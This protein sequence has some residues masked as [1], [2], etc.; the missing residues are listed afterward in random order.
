MATGIKIRGFSGA[1]F[2]N[3]TT[4]AVA[5]SLGVAMN[6]THKAVGKYYEDYKGRMADRMNLESIPQGDITFQTDTTRGTFRVIHAPTGIEIFGLQNMSIIGDNYSSLPSKNT[7][8]VEE[9]N[10]IAP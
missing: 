5:G 9:I 6:D 3:L 8:D 4:Q 10:N 1:S 7:D 2:G